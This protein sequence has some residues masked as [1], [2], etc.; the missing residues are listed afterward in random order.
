[1]TT[2]MLNCS[3]DV[4]E[5]GTN[6]KILTILPFEVNGLMQR[7]FNSVIIDVREA[8]DFIRG[9]IPNAVNLP[10]GNWDKIS[11][12]HDECLMIIYSHDQDC[13]LSHQ[14]A[15]TFAAY[16]YAVIAMEG[17]FAAWKEYNFQVER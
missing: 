5:Y 6:H 16:N 1:M 11:G 9:H 7:D 13:P 15:Q 8:S 3:Q 12:W 4:K 14:A 17:G 2:E 10:E